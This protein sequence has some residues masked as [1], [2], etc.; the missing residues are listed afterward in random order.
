MLHMNS[1]RFRLVTLPDVGMYHKKRSWNF[2]FQQDGS[3]KEHGKLIILIISDF[4]K[5]ITRKLGKKLDVWYP[6]SPKILKN[7]WYIANRLMT[8]YFQ[9]YCIYHFNFFLK[10]YWVIIIIIYFKHIRRFF[11]FKTLKRKSY[12]KFASN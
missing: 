12:Y 3:E 7:C 10:N 11:I 4:A 1:S 8:F 5:N 6:I 9:F 2:G